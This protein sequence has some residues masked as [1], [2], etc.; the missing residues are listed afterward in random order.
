MCLSHPTIKSHRT[1]SITSA[2]PYRANSRNPGY[3]NG[4]AKPLH[5]FVLPF[6]SLQFIPSFLHT[7]E[8]NTQNVPLS[9]PADDI[10]PAY[11]GAMSSVKYC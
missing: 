8:Y 1:L 11:S 5:S 4:K 10:V 7:Y 2:N 6:V 3:V 9:G